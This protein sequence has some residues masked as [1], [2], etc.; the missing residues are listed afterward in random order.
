MQKTVGGEATRWRVR[1]LGRIAIMTANKIT[2]KAM[3]IN[4]PREPP[5]RAAGIEEVEVGELAGFT[6]TVAV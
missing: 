3:K 6:P 5:H 4:H 1:R 2:Q